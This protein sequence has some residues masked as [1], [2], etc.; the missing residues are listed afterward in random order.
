MDVFVEE[1]RKFEVTH[2]WWSPQ[3]FSR[4]ENQTLKTFIQT[5]LKEHPV[6][7]TL[8]QTGSEEEF[9]TFLAKILDAS[10]KMITV[11]LAC[12]LDTLYSMD[13]TE[14]HISRAIV[15]WYR[16]EGWKFPPFLH[17]DG[18]QKIDE[19]ESKRPAT[20]ILYDA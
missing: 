14:Q 13:C 18:E 19:T 10:P 12:C 6:V 1:L 2:S 3:T 17:E 9:E 16:K 15:A 7:Q 20:D 8:L 5:T 11:T 4:L